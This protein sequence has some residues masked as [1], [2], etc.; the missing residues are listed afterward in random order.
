MLTKRFG[1]AFVLALLA[2]CSSPDEEAPNGQVE[3]F[4][5]WFKP[6]QV[7]AFDAILEVVA[8][9]QPH[10][11]VTN[12]AAQ[13]DYSDEIITVL[14]NR[15][16]QGDPPDT[17]QVHGGEELTST[18]VNPS[19][20]GSQNRMEPLDFLFD[21]QGWR[22]AFPP[23]L[24]EMLSHDGNVYSVPL[25]IHRGNVLYYNVAVFEANGVEPPTTW[26]EFFTVAQ[27][28]EA[29]GITP[30]ALGGETGYSLGQLFDSTLLAVGGAEYYNQFF[31]GERDP[32]G[33][34]QVLDTVDIM[35]E[36]MNHVQPD[37]E[38]YEWS[39]AAQMVVDGTAAM[40]IMGDWCKGYIQTTLEPGSEFG[41]VPVPGTAGS[42][43]V[44]TD[45]FPL[46]KGAPH[47]DNAL[48]LLKV[49][50]TREAGDAFNPLK[51]SIPARLDADT[52]LYDEMTQETMADF[53]EASTSTDPAKGLVPS[54]AHGSAAPQGFLDD[55]NVALQQFQASRDGNAL[56]QAI[57]N[58]YPRLN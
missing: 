1:G 26:D 58:A 50:G 37:P 41:H 18:W 25:N 52:S 4:H 17:F 43:V 21:E 12:S 3:V 29:A 35:V 48:A 27:V 49:F 31:R 5:Y 36:V 6:G 28:F 32:L 20:D 7:E 42:F 33:D 55:L 16:L 19:G 56:V 15:L 14:Q 54:L 30:L 34:N 2:G 8:Q 45:T 40:T 23:S 11:V 22:N 46:P 53:T 24:V 38:T 44:V 51:G 57:A 9:Q 13:I 10:L 47:R 39:D